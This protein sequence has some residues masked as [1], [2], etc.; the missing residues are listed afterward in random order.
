MNFFCLNYTFPTAGMN[1]WFMPN[2]SFPNFSFP[3]FSSFFQLPTLNYVNN[4]NNP[5][6][7]NNLY[8][9]VQQSV[10]TINNFGLRPQSQPTINSSVVSKSE[11]TNTDTFTRS[12]NINYAKD[13]LKLDDYNAFKGER[14]ARIALN[15][16]VGWTGYCATYVKKDIQA[17]GLGSY[18]LGDAYKMPKILR[19]NPNFKEISTNGVD[20]SKLPAGCV[21]V[22]GKGV[23]GYSDNYGH[24]EITLGDGRA[25][26]DGITKN[27]HKKP[28]NIFIPV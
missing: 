28:S 11:K 8:Y 18:K 23:E 9:P 21:L 13:E 25:A 15:N 16:S 10:F 26:S 17:A 3:N 22:Y 5:F 14:L 1:N 12:S 20:V 2:W 4:Q 24:T 6:L 19:N 27:L 7:F